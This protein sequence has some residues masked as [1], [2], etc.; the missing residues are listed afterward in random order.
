[1]K[2]SVAL[3]TY[4]GEKYL[5][6]Q[7]ESIARQTLTVDEILVCD[8]QST[9]HTLSIAQ[10]FLHQGLPLKI[11][12]NPQR[13]G[14]SRNFAQAIQRCQGD[15]IF[16]CDQDDRWHP[17]KVAVMLSYF[18][19]HPETLLLFSNG[20]LVNAEAQPLNCQ[21]WQALPSQPSVNPSFLD[22]LNH[23]WITGAACAFRRELIDYALPIPP[24]WIHDAWLGL[25]ASAVG[26]VKAIPDLLIQYRQHDNNQIGLKPP[27]LKQKIAKLH[28]L[29]TTQPITTPEKY[30]PLLE[31][32]PASHPQH[33]Y[34]AGKIRHLANRQHSHRLTGI[35]KE[36]L[37]NGY[38]QYAHGWKSVVRD[39]LLLSYQTRLGIQPPS[40]I[41]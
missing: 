39:L 26:E 2:L 41:K 40:E 6:E 20:E 9:D 1:M 17:D 16:L 32:L 18:S 3:C 21:L 35:F 15:I 11:Y 27:T 4:N 34:L 7:L 29:V 22:L 23:D 33:P 31:R 38:T 14:F 36:I 13:L 5:A 28:Q 24:Y 30:A 10:Q 37:N 8:D 19:Q 25:I 12:Q